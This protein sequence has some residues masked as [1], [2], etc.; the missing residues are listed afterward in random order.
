MTY[1]GAP[2]RAI[3]GTTCC[4]D[5]T[6]LE[7]QSR[8]ARGDEGGCNFC[9]GKILLTPQPRI[10]IFTSPNNGGLQVRICPKHRREIGGT[11]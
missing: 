3:E 7:M 4:H 6:A 10:W 11:G 9:A 8:P 5:H 2:G 1:D